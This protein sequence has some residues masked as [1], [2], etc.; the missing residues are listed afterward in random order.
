MSVKSLIFASSVAATVLLAGAFAVAQDAPKGDG[1]WAEHHQ[2][3]RAHMSGE[4]RA[5]LQIRPDQEAA[6]TTFQAALTPPPRPAEPAERPRED[7]TTPQIIDMHARHEA[8]RKAHADRVS[9]AV[10]TFYGA[11]SPAQQKAF[12]VVMR[13]HA[14]HGPGMMGGMGRGM[15]GPGMD[16]HD[17]DGHG[18]DGH[19]MMGPPPPPPPAG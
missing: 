4:L 2:A 9:S 10:L 14:M 6:F 12:D 16:G 13:R 17:R 7:L 8:E 15:R 11:L 3:M 5:I 18:M 1:R 19:R